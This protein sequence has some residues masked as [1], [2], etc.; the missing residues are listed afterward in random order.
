[1][2]SPWYTL[3]KIFFISTWSPALDVWSEKSDEYG[4]VD[5]WDGMQQEWFK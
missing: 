4:E 3:T 1:M 5:D 2:W